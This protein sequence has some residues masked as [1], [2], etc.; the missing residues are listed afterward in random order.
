MFITIY[1]LDADYKDC[2]VEMGGA[3]ETHE[4]GNVI[5][6]EFNVES[7]GITIFTTENG[8]V[9]ITSKHD[10]GMVLSADEFL[11]IKIN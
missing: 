2:A 6:V 11:S 5:D 8:C 1:A 10:I 9:S 4:I 3:I 7:D